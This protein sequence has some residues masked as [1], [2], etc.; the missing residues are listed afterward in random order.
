L[1]E[2]MKKRT[3]PIF[4]ALAVCAAV[5]IW[6]VAEVSAVGGDL[7]YLVPAPT[8]VT[9]TGGQSG[10]DTQADGQTD[11]QAAAAET[12]TSETQPNAQALALLTG[13]QT[14]AE[15][16]AASYRIIRYPASWKARR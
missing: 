4:L 5:L 9:G 8:V 7:Q 6:S 11:A 13:L 16:W 10:G 1:E 2:A 3:I 15:D 12:Q 14:A